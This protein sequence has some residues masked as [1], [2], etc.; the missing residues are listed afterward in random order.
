MLNRVLFFCQSRKSRDHTVLALKHAHRV[1]NAIQTLYTSEQS[2]NFRLTSSKGA[3]RPTLEKLP[4]DMQEYI[5]RKT[6]ELLLELVMYIAC[7]KRVSALCTQVKLEVC[8]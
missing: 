4:I 5:P 7:Y 8:L 1:V 3:P 6:N 2:T